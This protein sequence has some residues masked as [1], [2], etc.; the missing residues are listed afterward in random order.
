MEQ[1][2]R[3]PWMVVF[4]SVNLPVPARRASSLILLC[5][6][7]S[8]PPE[9]A[10]AQDVQDP[11]AWEA[12]LPDVARSAERGQRIAV[13]EADLQEARTA[14]EMARL[15]AQAELA[16]AMA[17]RRKAQLVAAILMAL[18]LI[19]LYGR[20]VAKGLNKDL[21]RKVEERTAELS[22]ANLRLKDLILTD[23]LTGL[24]NRRYL[25]QT[26]ETDL[27]VTL[28]A[29]RDA[30]VAGTDPQAAD[31][32]FYIID[33]D[34]F[35]T[36]NDE[37]GH[38]A[39]DRVLEQVARVLQETSRASDVVIRWG[40][41]EFLVLSRQ[42]DRH[43]AAVFAERVREAVRGHL[44]VADEGVTLRKTCS[45]GFAAFPFVPSDPRAVAWDHVVGLA[46]QAAYAA[47]RSGR[48]A[49]VGFIATGETAP[50]AVRS[51]AATVATLVEHGALGVVSSVDREGGGVVLG[52]DL[53]GRLDRS[54]D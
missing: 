7:I 48:D 10:I 25:L 13:R 23:P 54:G 45:I 26:V 51:D 6:A 16:S 27:A 34:E 21:E 17:Q 35:K 38:A 5:L 28:R 42:V 11:A 30:S 33:L 8:G 19:L 47:K 24:R 53:S 12:R 40:G 18:V 39:G 43:G 31:T 3:P 37:H 41:E 14:Q 44:F 9:A 46:D 49:W 52:D 2:Y 32:V 1:K 20:H 15:R 50:D 29:Y 4:L 36:V 22:A